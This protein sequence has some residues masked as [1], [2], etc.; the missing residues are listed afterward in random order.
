M[1][2]QRRRWMVAI[3]TVTAGVGLSAVAAVSQVVAEVP[4]SAG[5]SGAT[6]SA[7]AWGTTVSAPAGARGQLFGATAP[8]PGDVWA[9]GGSNPGQPPTSVL[10][11]PYAEHWTGTAWSATTL[12][13]PKIY[14]SASQAAQL[15]GAASTGP[16]DVWAVGHIDDVSSLASRT[17][18]YHWD[19]TAWTRTPTPNPGGATLGNHLLAV[20]ARASDDV[21]AV[22]DT[23]YPGR[24]LVI[25]WNGTTWAKVT[26]PNIGNLTAVTADATNV[27]VAAGTTVQRLTGG[28][29]TLLPAVPA[30]AG[31]VYLSGLAASSTGL[32]AVGT[33]LIP[34]FEGYLYRPY[35]AVWN[36]STW[37]KV[38]APADAGLNAVT[39]V[40][41]DVFATSANAVVR[42][43]PSGG[44]LEVTPALTS[45]FLE[46][47]TA[48]RDGHPWAVGWAS[49]GSTLVPAIINAP[50]IDQ[51]GISVTTGY[52]GATVTWIG[53]SAGSGSATVFGTFAVAG[54]PVG[55]YTIVVSASGCTPGVASVTV[56]AGLVTAVNAPVTC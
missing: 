18:A 22:G 3:G 21:Y 35:A 34:Y 41:S 43:T 46:G 10:T 37:S 49:S 54:L 15:E 47:I 5:S 52:A 2:V 25:R 16:S 11:A 38:S 4:V 14:P 39:A 36:G 17:L 50:G 26:T 23:G 42:L 19:G 31:S 48:D 29:W 51:G 13:V 7:V 20:A 44:T 8:A 28:V 32:W 55:A 9:V 27:W 1:Q 53:P 6:S 33:D 40:G 56:T 24:S 30:G 45:T 12:K